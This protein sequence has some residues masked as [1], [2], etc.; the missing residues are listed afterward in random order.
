MIY[1][2]DERRRCSSA[3]PHRKY[4]PVHPFFLTA[5][6]SI[7]PHTRAER[8]VPY[9]VFT[10]NDT[11]QKCP[12]PTPGGSAVLRSFFY[13]LRYLRLVP[14]E[15]ELL[16]HAGGVIVSFERNIPPEQAGEAVGIFEKI[17]PIT[18]EDIERSLANLNPKYR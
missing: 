15:K 18:D 2:R 3:P 14:A 16:F 12:H 5:L 11:V 1:D 7:L 8:R 13:F 4:H 9:Q 17:E 6:F 10:A